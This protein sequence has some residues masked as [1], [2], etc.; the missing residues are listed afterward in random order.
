[1]RHFFKIYI[2]IVMMMVLSLSF[3][4]AQVQ[5]SNCSPK[6]YT[7]ETINGVFTDKEG[8]TEN[9]SALQP[10]LLGTFNNQPLTVDFLHNPSHLAG[11]E[12]F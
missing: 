2:T 3:T 1:M 9:S 7:I 11:W 10:K 6:G 4:F 8:A 5:S 12:M